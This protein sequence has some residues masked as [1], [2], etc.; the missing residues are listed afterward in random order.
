[1]TFLLQFST[2]NVCMQMMIL[3]Q[4]EH[5]GDDETEG[6]IVASVTYVTLKLGTLLTTL[7]YPRGVRN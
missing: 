5:Q 7:G 3:I 1:M 6:E 2:E 4:I